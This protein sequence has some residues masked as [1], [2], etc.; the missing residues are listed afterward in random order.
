M[1]KLPYILI[2]RA[3]GHF[4]DFTEKLENALVRDKRYINERT[5]YLKLLDTNQADVTLAFALSDFIARTAQL[6]PIQ[7]MQKLPAIIGRPNHD[8]QQ[9][10]EYY[11]QLQQHL[12]QALA[13]ENNEASLHKALRQFRHL[14]MLS[15]AWR[16]LVYKA[17]IKQSL[18]AISH[19]ADALINSANDWLYRKACERYGNPARVSQQLDDGAPALHQQE[20]LIIGMG[21][22]GGHELNFSSD[23]DLI[24]VYPESGETDHPRKPIDHQTFFTRLAQK[25]I[26]ALHQTTMDGQVYR[27]DMRLRPLGD[28][29]PLVVS[30]PAF[31]S[32]YLEQG[33]E[34]ERF[35]MQKARV[36]NPDSE[37][38][39]ELQSIITPFVYRKYLDFTTLE[40]LR[41]MKKLIANEVARRNLTNNIKLGKG[42]IREVE[43]FVQ[44]LQM[45]HAGKVT[46]CQTKSILASFNALVEHELLSKQDAAELQESY[47]FLRQVEHYLQAF[48]DKQTQKLPDNE[49]DKARLSF[50]L[51][52][53]PLLDM[54]ATHQ[55]DTIIDVDFEPVQRHMQRINR[56]FMSLIEE[57]H[58]YKD[59]NEA[60]NQSYSDL[61]LLDLDK[62]EMQGLFQSLLGDS[63]ESG[64][65][66]S[67][68]AE[69]KLKCT[70]HDIGQRGH[71]TLNKLIPQLLNE[72]LTYEYG[73]DKD[74]VTEEH[75]SHLFERIF[76]ILL[77]IVGRTTYLDLLL[78]NPAVRRRLITL[79]ANS[80]WVAKQVK[81]FPLLLDELLHPAYLQTDQ[82][83]IVTWRSEYESELRL[84]LL[85]VETDDVEAQMDALRYFKLTQQLRIAAADITGTLPINNVSDKLTVL[86]EVLLAQ[87]I[88]IAWIQ[89]ATPY[90]IPD[91]Y[92]MQNK[93][94]GVLAYGK[95]GGIELGYGSDLDIVF[96]HDVNLSTMT[97]GAKQISCSEFFV[98][99]VQRVTHIFTTKTY[100]NDLYEIDLRLR[101]SGNSG[102]LISH[103]DTFSDYQE[104]DAW[105]WEHQALVRARYVYGHVAL[106]NKF[107]DIRM[108]VLEKKREKTQLCKEVADMREKM[109]RHLDK[110]DNKSA[111]LKQ[112]SGGITDL[113]FLT[114]YW[115]LLHSH[116]FSELTTWSDN[117]RILDS[118]AQVDVISDSQNKALQEAYLFIRNQLHKLSLGAFGSNN[119]VPG[120]EKHMNVIRSNYEKVFAV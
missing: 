94:L 74:N 86:A 63:G 95:M 114:Q 67:Q 89:I 13:T 30:M 103:I 99:L 20:L 85:R 105:T 28:S 87:V 23:I 101:P 15:I 79:S 98:K 50:L 25:L 106:R 71:K 107:T 60:L 29:G 1:Q 35:A 57:D 108:R 48:D 2:E 84:Q 46:E 83:D 53:L 42:G 91:G 82:A 31:E 41:N 7:F 73:A 112:T 40:S 54:P 90:G 21:K 62:L 116:Q 38:V 100:L 92:S 14:T 56:H 12:Q 68:L 78:E 93:G 34:W 11:L 8:G 77:T 27:V 109:R 113:E 58:E 65:L 9:Y 66:S 72:V 96:V 10:Q 32:Y 115:V 5:G 43:F 45:I 44:S 117:L 64:K 55:S 97:N 17:D 104:N 80:N 76:N 33:R 51:E 36:I 111:D 37:L 88:D 119:A 39:T 18:L 61:W 4:A 22:L 75:A 24:F 118:L 19:L 47:L 6:Y 70:K 16:D 81:A 26:A 110:S 120:L 59:E 49:V 52:T 69:F 3:K 102:L